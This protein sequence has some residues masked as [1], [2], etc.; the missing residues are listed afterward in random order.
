MSTLT[1]RI[2]AR[3]TLPA[4]PLRRA[5]REAAGLSLDDI[6]REI[7]VT[8]QAVSFWERG[9]R[10]PRPDHLIAYSGLLGQLKEES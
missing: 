4:P 1:Q 9:L 7:G 3:K 10:R 8:G 5:L 2:Q 6:G